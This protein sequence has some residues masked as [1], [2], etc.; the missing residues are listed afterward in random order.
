MVFVTINPLNIAVGEPVTSDLLAQ[1]KSNEDDH[2]S[3]ILALEG[4]AAQVN[5]INEKIIIGAN[6]TSQLTGFHDIEILQSAIIVE[7]AIQL[8]GKS[9]AT[10]G[11]ITVDVKKNSTTNPTGFNSIFTSPPSLDISVA[12]DFSRTT[13]TINPT[14]QSVSP[15]DI[16]R[17]DI[18]SLP[19]GLQSIR[20]TLVGEI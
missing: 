6:S 2:E 15:G 1:Y 8:Y 3:R 5:L 4:G 11:T 14:Y 9:P 17:V 7:G 12:S 19:A 16:L 10:S 18:T 13:G 20:L